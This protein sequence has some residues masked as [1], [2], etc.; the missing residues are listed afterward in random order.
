MVLPGSPKADTP[1]SASHE[2]AR[3]HLF[4]FVYVLL[5]NRGSVISNYSRLGEANNYEWNIVPFSVFLYG[6]DDA[7]E[8]PLV[9]SLSLKQVI[10]EQYRQKH[11]GELCAGPPCTTD[12]SV[13]WRDMVAETFIRGVY[14]FAVHTTEAQDEW[15]IRDF[16]HRE[17]V[18]H[19]TLAAVGI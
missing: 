12:L 19:Y 16:N 17:N 3:F 9:A 15:F 7:S 13:N 4:N 11:L 6:F 8:R 1:P 2:Y 14:L 5:A 10:E 18:N